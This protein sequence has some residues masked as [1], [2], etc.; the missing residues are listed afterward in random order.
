MVETADLIGE[1]VVR[2][3]GLG[4]DGYDAV[5]EVRGESSRPKM[6]YLD[7]NL[8]FVSHDDARVDGD[9]VVV[10][11]Q[12]GWDGYETLLALPGTGPRMTYLDGNLFLMTPSTIHELWVDR[13]GTFVRELVVGLEIPC[14]PTRETIFRRGP[15]EGGV[16]PDDSFYLAHS[17]PIAA[18]KR[19]ANIDLAVDPPP[20][21]VI[22][23]VHTHDAA[24]AVEVYR[25][26]GVPEVWVCDANRLQ[27]LLRDEAGSY[28]EADRSGA[29]PFLTASEIFA[30]VARTDRELLADWV[31]TLR[32]WIA[33][34]VMPRIQ[35]G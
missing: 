18:K 9:Q 34:V 28:H 29:F 14:L 33:E 16:Q 30:W 4:W 19:Q 10:L 12:V 35:P 11:R 3:T 15:D 24:H 6:L 26:L 17:G 27:I 32:Q 21:L 23:F 1:Q 25:R 2:W 13:L 5:L 7:G 8:T 20:D 31:R 22:E